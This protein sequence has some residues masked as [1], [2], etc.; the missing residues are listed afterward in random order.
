VKGP[1]AAVLRAFEVNAEPEP[2][3]GGTGRTWLAGDVVLKPI[4]NE[5]EHA[6]VSE[7]CEAWESDTVAVPLPLRAGTEWSAFGWGAQVLMP[8]RTARA[9]EDPGWFRQVCD[10]FHAV[11]RLLARPAFLEARDDAWAFGD[12]VAWEGLAPQGADRTLTLLERAIARL[13]PV[14]A[15]DQVVHGDLGGNL[16]RIEER[17]AVIDWPPYWR[18]VDWALAVAAT[19]AVCWEGADESLLDEWSTGEQWPQHLL[20][21]A[22]YRLATRGRNEARGHVPVG[23]DASLVEETR[24]LDL[25]EKRLR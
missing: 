3:P 12:R 25:I 13:K 10:D 19:D 9:G 7:V 21:A 2:L 5:V 23:S 20:R 11:T 22:V 17:A 16:L 24:L 1:P 14:D 8:G 15:T 18:P 4:D 6:W